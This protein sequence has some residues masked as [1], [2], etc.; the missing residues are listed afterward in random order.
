MP[1]DT[2]PALEAM[3]ALRADGVDVMPVGEE[4]DRWR[5]GDFTYSDADLCRLALSRGLIQDDA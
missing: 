1:D 4:L 2:D 3:N 5:V